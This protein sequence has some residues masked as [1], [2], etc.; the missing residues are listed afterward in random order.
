MWASYSGRKYR[1]V[2]STGLGAVLPSPPKAGPA[3]VSASS[4]KRSS[5]PRVPLPS[6]ISVIISSIRS[7]PS[8]HGTHLPQDSSCKNFRKYL[9]TSTIQELSSMT[10]IPPEPTTEPA[11]ARIS[12]S[13]GRANF[14]A[15]RH[16]PDG[17]PICTA[18]ILLPFTDPPPMSYTTSLIGIPIGTSTS[19]VFLILPVRARI[20]VPLLPFV[21]LELNHDEPFRII[22]GT[23]AQVSTLFSVVGL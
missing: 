22:D 8:R 14:S 21:P 10:T 23:F 11:S 20:L 3:P 12:K 7:I 6:V 13:T 16:P 5:C 1:R 15:G 9:A 17:P 2:V 18:L 19:P 4:S